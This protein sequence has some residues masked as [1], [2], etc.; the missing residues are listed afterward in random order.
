[1]RHDGYFY[2]SDIRDRNN[3]LGE[4]DD[5]A[6]RSD[7]HYALMERLYKN[8]FVR[9]GVREI[10][11]F[12]LEDVTFSRLTAKLNGKDKQTICFKIFQRYWQRTWKAISRHHGKGA[13]L[14]SRNIDRLMP[15]RNVTRI[16]TRPAAH[17]TVA[18]YR[19]RSP[20]RRHVSERTHSLSEF[21]IAGTDPVERKIWA[22]AL[23]S[24]LVQKSGPDNLGR[25]VKTSNQDLFVEVDATNRNKAKDL[26]YSSHSIS[27][28]IPLFATLK[29]ALFS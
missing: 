29:S 25:S 3:V 15:C 16:G 20:S 17:P 8:I 7:N 13:S 9:S 18:V 1:M 19:S 14:T 10:D 2:I 22:W 4:R 5:Y 26:L 11:I 12:G 6:L 23:H 27:S 21:L 24:Q 28:P